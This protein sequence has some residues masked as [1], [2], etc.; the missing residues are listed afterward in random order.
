MRL[1]RATSAEAPGLAAAHAQAFDAP[2]R[3]DEFEDLLEG[4]GIFGFLAQDP[5]PCG[6][7]LCRVAGG[8]MEVLT[9]AV[10]PAARR[11]GMGGALLTAALNQARLMSAEAA[12][13]EVAV[14]NPVA[15]ALY[16]KAGFQRAGVR[17]GYSDRGSAGLEDAVVMRLTL[18]QDAASPY[19]PDSV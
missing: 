19:N 13:L 7:I 17:R 3:E 14:G 1:L 18:T 5:D 8:E 9:L 4:E 6:M 11:Q 10:S 15:E 12:F 2:W 16:A